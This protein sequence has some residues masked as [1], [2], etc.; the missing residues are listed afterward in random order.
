[1]RRSPQ[2]R[3]NLRRSATFATSTPPSSNKFTP[4]DAVELQAA[5]VGSVILA[6]TDRYDDLR[7][8]FLRTYESLPQLICYCEVPRDVQLSLAFAQ[9]HGLIP[10]CRSGGH[11]TAGFSVNDEMVIDLSRISYVVVDEASR[12]ARIGAGTN[13]EKVQAA[14]SPFGLHVPGGGCPSVAVA[15]YMQGGGYSFTSQ[16]F[17]MNCDSV[18][19]CV[20]A[21]AAGEIVTADQNRHPDL[22]W[23]LRGGTGNNF[24][25]LL[26]ITYRLHEVGELRGFG[27]S[28]S[29]GT[30]LDRTQA[31][32]ALSVWQSHYAG[33][34]AGTDMGIELFVVD[35]VRDPAAPPQPELLLR[36]MDR[37][38][39]AACKAALAPLTDRCPDGGHHD[40]W[41][42]GTYEQLNEY[43][44]SSP[45]EL[46]DVP[47]NIR[48][49]VES[50]IVA[51]PLDTEDWQHLLD[52]FHAA[53]PGAIM[54]VIE[55]YGGAI[56]VPAPDETAFVH[57]RALMNV[58]IWSF[59]MYDDEREQAERYISDFRAVLDPLSNGH[60]NQNYPNRATPLDLYPQLYWGENYPTLQAVKA[61]Y[62]PGILFQFPHMVHPPA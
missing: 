49:L 55:S 33:A 52:F 8:G 50:R 18:I 32:E 57:R 29:L 40:I 3:A 2:H 46:P 30:D 21:S 22:F 59:W 10:V 4:Q 39:E 31:A 26:E 41:C 12:T 24:G 45:T 35:V 62:D 11:S 61:K 27:L 9:R 54:I 56:N 19:E 38:D 17:G 7:M 25:V 34:S 13:F 5:M 43:L 51:D 14:L 37:R 16:M 58:F 36:G 6:S 44:L 23:A 20:V 1:M 60:A 42:A 48:A 47:P 53:E 28:W 15:G